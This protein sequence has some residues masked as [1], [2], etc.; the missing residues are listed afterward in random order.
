[1]SGPSY[2]SA[3]TLQNGKALIAYRDG[4]NS[5]YGT[6]LFSPADLQLQRVDN[7]QAR[8]WNSTQE[9]LELLLS[10]NQ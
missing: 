1:G 8:L 3:T 5:N 7:N 9:T 10:L 4:G 2:V 6:L